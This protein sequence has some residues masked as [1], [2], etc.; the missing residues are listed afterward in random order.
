M[1]QNTVITIVVIL[2]QIF[3]IGALYTINREIKDTLKTP[4]VWDFSQIEGG[5]L[6]CIE[7]GVK[8]GLEIFDF[9]EEL[10]PHLMDRP[11]DTLYLRATKCMGSI[12]LEFDYNKK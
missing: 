11:Q 1:K 12:C 4:P 7:Y 2:T 3:C 8:H 6:D 10:V 9:P 5:D